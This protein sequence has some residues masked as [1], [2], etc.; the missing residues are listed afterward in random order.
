[1]PD[2]NIVTIGAPMLPDPVRLAGLM[3]EIIESGWF[4]NCGSLHN[5]L[6]QALAGIAGNR[7]LQLVSSGTM[8]LM[9]ALRLGNLP[10]GA[11]VIT[12]PLSFAATVQAIAWCG[13]RPI[14]ADVDPETLT[15]CP[16]AVEAAV[17]PRTAAILPVHL[18]GV[19]CDVEGLDQVARRHGLW[20]AY[21]AAHAFGLTLSGRPIADH[22]DATAF[23]LN[24]TKVLHTGEGGFVVTR[25]SSEAERL[26]MS[27]NF[28]LKAGQMVG[29]GTNGKLSEAHAAIGLALLPDLPAEIAARE[30]LRASYDAVF[31]DLPG[32]RIQP[33]RKGAS[34]GLTMYALRLPPSRR[35][36]LHH[37]LAQQGIRT[38]NGFPV[39]CG[40]GTAWP[41]APIAT[42]SS[43]P[44]APVVGPEVICLPFHARV[45]PAHVAQMADIAG[46]VI[47]AGKGTS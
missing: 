33:T 38:R 9:Q 7:P 18:L 20:L 36:Q 2:P 42:A 28:G 37:E 32:L 16:R 35:D 14:F 46:K 22:G 41:D 47:G 43:A 29:Q 8:A 40:P 12:S 34:D 13:F 6:E 26:S 4:T 21:D 17:T 45:T 1:M 3:N 24:A 30:R 27:R 23:S 10:E 11:E 25:D 19:P 44:V 31:S 15:L 39:L 5:R